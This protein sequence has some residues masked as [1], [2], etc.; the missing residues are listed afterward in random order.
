M[1]LN[2][3]PTKTY[4]EHSDDKVDFKAYCEK[5]SRKEAKLR[6]LRRNND[7]LYLDV[8]KR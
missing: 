6:E 7:I 3:K 1:I 5:L 2:Y 4:K 8:F